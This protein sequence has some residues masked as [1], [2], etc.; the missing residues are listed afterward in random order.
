MVDFHYEFIMKNFADVKLGF[1]DTDSF[2]YQIPCEGNI[3]TKLQELDPEQKWMDFSNYDVHHPN[4]SRKNHLVPGNV[5][6]L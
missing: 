6:F 2:L 5:F 4:Y 1:T 3:Y